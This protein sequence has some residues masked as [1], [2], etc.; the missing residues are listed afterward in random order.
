MTAF[1]NSRLRPPTGFGQS[2]PGGRHSNFL[3][4]SRVTVCV[5]PTP[6]FEDPF[7]FKWMNLRHFSCKVASGF[8][9]SAPPGKD[10]TSGL[11]VDRQE[12]RKQLRDEL[13]EQSV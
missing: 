12:R 10:W 6:D 3:Q 11:P 4:L 13:K 7:N 9:S 8:K 1:H 2:Q 5:Q